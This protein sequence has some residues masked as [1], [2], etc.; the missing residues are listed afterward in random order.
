MYQPG[1]IFYFTPFYFSDGKTA[2]KNKYFIVLCNGKDEMIV[3]SLPSSQDY[4]P[5]F[6]QKAHGCI[7]IPDGGFNCYYFSPEKA[8]TA[9]GWRFP[10][11]TYMYANWI[12]TFNLTIFK[13][14]Y[15]VE[16]VDYEIIGRLTKYEFEEIIKCFFSS[17]IT[18]RKYKPFLQNVKY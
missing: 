2:P 9:D 7:D 3:A 15:V 17:S 1:T 6:A 13:N 8:V 4:V 11:P 10:M 14:V 12:D 16:G 5:A 18:K